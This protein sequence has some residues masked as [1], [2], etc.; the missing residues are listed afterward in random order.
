MFVRLE[1]GTIVN[2]AKIAM[3]RREEHVWP[4]MGELMWRV[5]YDDNL[6]VFI[7]EDDH[8]NIMK[9]IETIGLL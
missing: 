6:S 4:G 8:A 9:V 5:W 7:T 1:G 3:L 2:V